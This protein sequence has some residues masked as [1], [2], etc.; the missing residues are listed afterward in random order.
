MFASQKCFLAK[1]AANVIS[2]AN[3]KVP[4]TLKSHV[5][6]PSLIQRIAFCFKTI[7]WQ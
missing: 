7:L 1:G 4:P 5:S 6:P 2:T 3:Y